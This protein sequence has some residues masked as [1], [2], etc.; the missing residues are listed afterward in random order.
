ME[1]AHDK[2]M[3]LKLFHIIESKVI[4]MLLVIRFRLY[5]GNVLF[6]FLSLTLYLYVFCVHQQNKDINCQ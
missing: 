1:P 5:D 6:I 4:F 3:W 2:F